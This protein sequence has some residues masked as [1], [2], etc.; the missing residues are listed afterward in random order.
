[1]QEIWLT[2][3]CS[4]CMMWL[5]H[6]WKFLPAFADT[7]DML[8]CPPC[9]G[10]KVWLVCFTTHSGLRLKT[11]MKILSEILW[12]HQLLA[13][14]HSY[15][16]SIHKGR[17]REVCNSLSQD[18]V[19]AKNWCKFKKGPDIFTEE[20][21]PL[22]RTKT[23]LPFQEVLDPQI[24]LAGKVIQRGITTGLSSS[25]LDICHHSLSDRV[26]RTTFELKDS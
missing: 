7:N 17:V 2:D 9:W 26:Q 19:D 21:M 3:L 10:L 14:D 12:S 22:S 25:S 15:F 6:L 20:K 16:F 23:L 13:S 5:L 24:E 4:Q 11:W 18:L 8:S 1:M